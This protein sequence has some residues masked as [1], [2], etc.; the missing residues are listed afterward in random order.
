MIDISLQINNKQRVRKSGKFEKKMTKNGY[1]ASCAWVM[2]I[3]DMNYQNIK[4]FF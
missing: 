4:G 2:V 3:I 1:Y